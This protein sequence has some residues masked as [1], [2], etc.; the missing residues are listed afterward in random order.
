MRPRVHEFARERPL[1]PPN[2]GLPQLSYAPSTKSVPITL[3]APCVPSIQK[4]PAGTIHLRR[5]ATRLLSQ[6]CLPLAGQA[7]ALGILRKL[8]PRH[9][10]R[11]FSRVAA[12]RPDNAMNPDKSV[13]AHHAK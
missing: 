4:C 12:W 8:H 6:P 9:L 11:P 13:T 2:R 7:F 5:A 10:L 1:S 3:I